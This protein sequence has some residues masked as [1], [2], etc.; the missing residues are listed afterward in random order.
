MVTQEEVL[1]FIARRTRQ[2]GSVSYRDLVHEFGLSPEAAY[3]HLERLWRNRLI[4]SITPRP[5]RYHFRRLPR[6]SLRDLR[7]RVTSRG[8]ERLEWARQRDEE[9]GLF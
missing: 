9:G 6:E 5:P 7:F 1:S 3:G 2:G 8:Q 4:E